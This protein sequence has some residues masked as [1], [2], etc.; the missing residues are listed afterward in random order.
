MWRTLKRKTGLWATIILIIVAYPTQAIG[1]AR[2]LQEKMRDG[3]LLKVHL[4]EGYTEEGYGYARDVLQ[5]AC[6]G[7]NE[8]VFHQGFNRQGYSFASANRFF[9]YDSDRAIDIFI[10]DVE[11]PFAW[12]QIE[13]GLKYKAEIYLPVDYQEYRRRYKIVHPEL[14]LKANLTHELLHIITYSYNRNM[15]TTS[16]GSASLTSSR[17]DWYNEGLAR[18]FESL[19][20]YQ[21]EFLSA[22]YREKCGDKI[23]VYK[24][25]V[26]YFLTYPDKPLEQR[27]YDFALFWKYLHQNYGMDKIEEISF[28]FRQLDPLSCSNQEAMEVIAQTLEVP[29]E[30]LLRNFSLY[31]YRASS[32]PG[33]EGNG[34]KPVFI[35]KITGRRGEAHS[36]CSFGFDFYE[37]DLPEEPK[38]IELETLNGRQNLNCLLGIRSAFNSSSM[39]VEIGGQGKIKIDTTY[40]PQNSKMIIMLSNPTDEAIGYRISSN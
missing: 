7:Y 24:G 33:E 25:G 38:A 37:I 4:P 13:D 5:A 39:P 20:G 12:M 15:Q 29:L 14:E 17:W 8:I 27:K 3:V 21:D 22:G 35:S 23:I 18:Y 30:S 11:A 1:D 26:N 6:L 2:L 40:L 31:V 36:I 19:V 28:K 9:A 16:Q 10:A 32:L 34:L